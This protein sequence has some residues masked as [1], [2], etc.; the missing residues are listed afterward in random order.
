[1]FAVSEA[2]LGAGI[3]IALGTWGGNW[4][5]QKLHTAPW[6]SISLSIIGAGLG[7]AR[8]IIKA[9]QINQPASEK[10]SATSTSSSTD[11]SSTAQP[12]SPFAKWEDEDN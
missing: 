3:L 1:M 9:Q 5:D 2:I 8:L 10:K 11:T 12:R 7:L 4:L 6:L